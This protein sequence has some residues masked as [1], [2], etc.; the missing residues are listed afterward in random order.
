MTSNNNE[1][2]AAGE[3]PVPLMNIVVSAPPTGTAA[4]D[5]SVWRVEIK[6]ENRD[7]CCMRALAVA[8]LIVI[9]CLAVY[10]ILY[11]TLNISKL[12]AYILYG[13]LM[14]LALG[15]ALRLA[16]FYEQI[17]TAATDV[18]KVRG[19]SDASHAT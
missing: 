17:L 6:P 15:S 5:H 14:V 11:A 8:F 9:A 10:M 7:R 2:V 18:Q 12:P 4:T 13:V 16:F 1:S 3:P 19:K